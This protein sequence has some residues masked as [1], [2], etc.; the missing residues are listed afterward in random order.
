MKKYA[1]VYSYQGTHTVRTLCDTKEEAIKAEQFIRDMHNPDGINDDTWVEEIEVDENGEIVKEQ[2]S[3]RLASDIIL[4]ANQNVVH[5]TYGSGVVIKR[6]GKTDA[7]IKF[8]C[9]ERTVAML[10][11]N[12]I[13]Y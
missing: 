6:V 9:G 8:D 11:D 3:Y 5:K 13:K 7:L 10:S 4:T 1:A 12:F 2:G